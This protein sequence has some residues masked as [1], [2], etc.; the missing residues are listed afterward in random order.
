MRF[1][2]IRW[3]WRRGRWRSHLGRCWLRLNF[4]KKYEVWLLYI[5]CNSVK[6]PKYHLKQ[7][8]WS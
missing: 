5:I 1:D 8:I 2:N 6:L 4:L 7:K 3:R